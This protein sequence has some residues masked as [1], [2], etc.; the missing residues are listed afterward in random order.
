MEIKTIKDFYKFLK[1]YTKKT[2]K[3]KMFRGVHNSTYKLIPSVGRLKTYTGKKLTIDEEKEILKDFENKAYLYIK[4]FNF[5]KLDLLSFGRHHG[6]PTRLLDWAQNPLVAMY[7]AVEKPFTKKEEKQNECSRVYICKTEIPIEP[8]EPFDPFEIK[9]VN[10]YVPKY[11]DNRIIAQRGLFTVHNDPYTP[12]KP[13]GLKI[14]KIHKNI[15]GEIKILLNRMGINASALY[16][17]IDG[18]AKHVEWWHSSL[19]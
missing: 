5:N 14:V 15:R 13:N 16:P 4:D 1:K 17:D 19:H 7:F 10:Y 6:L 3:K 18:I 12:W 9:N 8:C 11:S 2:N